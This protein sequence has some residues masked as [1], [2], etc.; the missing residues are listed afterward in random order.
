[1]GE[2]YIKALRNHPIVNIVAIVDK[3][4]KRAKNIVNTYK[5]EKYY[6]NIQNLFE[7]N[8][9]D[10]VIIA[11]P[12]TQH[13]EPAIVAAENNS[14]ILVEKPIA[15]T[16]SDAEDMVK[17]ASENNVILMVGHILRF[18]PRY[19]IAKEII[20]QGRI[21]DIISIWGRRLNPILTPQRVGKWTDPMFYLGIHD[22]DLMLWYKQ[23]KAITIYS[24]AVF[25]KLKE[26]YNINVP[27]VIYTM[28]EF[29]DH[30]LGSLEINWVL[31]ETWN[32]ML[33]ARMHIYGTKGTLFI[34]IDS[35]ELSYFTETE[36]KN[37]DT[38][39]WPI[40]DGKM[41]GDLRNEIEHFIDCIIHKKEPVVTGKDGLRALKITLAIMESYKKNKEVKI[42]Y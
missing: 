21:G 12:E 36:W 9:L 42:Y 37:P 26:E 13:K 35:H 41:V 32:R 11:T 27:D 8:K 10:A 24:K 16:I 29:E 6:T 33:E 39:H 7:E 22:V 28:I 20:S 1:M 34:D 2:N 15:H 25:K 40:I 30:T 19:A 17:A 23:E 14:H 4:R 38:L 5:I 3:D 18:D 31:P